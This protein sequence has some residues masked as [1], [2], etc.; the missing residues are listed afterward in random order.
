MGYLYLFYGVRV[1]GVRGRAVSIPLRSAGRR[2]CLLLRANISHHQTP[3][4]GHGQ[5]GSRC[6]GNRGV[7]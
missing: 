7:T 1:A 2:L 3:E 4:Q 6:R 5:R